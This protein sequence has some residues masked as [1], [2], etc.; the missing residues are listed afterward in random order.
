MNFEEAAPRTAELAW[1]KSS[2]SDGEGGNCVEVAGGP[3]TVR[4]RDSKDKPG[5][6]L[7]FTPAEWSTFVTYAAERG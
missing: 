6:Q 4:V 2:Y 5:P 1:L 3:G 7:A